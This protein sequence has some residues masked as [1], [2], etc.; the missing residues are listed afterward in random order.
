MMTVKFFSRWDF[1]KFIRKQEELGSEISDDYAIISINDN[2]KE[3][4]E[5]I[6]HVF[7]HT[8]N[9]KAY[10][11]KFQDVDHHDGTGISNNQ[12]KAMFNFIKENDG[13]HFL[14][15][16]FAGMSRSA[17]V[18]KFINDYYDMQDHV[19]ENYKIYNKM[20]YGKLNGFLG[21]MSMG[22]YYRQLEEEDRRGDTI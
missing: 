14:V 2:Q 1:I 22:D 15:H 17:A 4:D 6:Q 13:K 18:A 8:T 9:A 11:V 21:K 3:L 7:L 10:Y 19:L 20:V 5:M 16:C 12:A